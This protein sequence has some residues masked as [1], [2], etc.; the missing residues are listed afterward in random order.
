MSFPVTF[1]EF[2]KKTNSTKQPNAGTTPKKLFTDVTLKDDTD[3]LNPTLIIKWGEDLTFTPNYV[4]IAIFNRFYYVVNM[5]WIKGLWH[6]QCKVDVLATYK[7]KIGEQSLYVTRSSA[8]SDGNIIDTTYPAEGVPTIT[9]QL[10]T[11]PW[12]LSQDN[13]YCYV[14]GIA[15][16]STTFFAMTLSQLQIF[17]QDFVLSNSYCDA[18]YGSTAWLT[19]YPELKSLMNPLQYIVSIKWYPFEIS[20][21][22]VDNLKYGWIRVNGF[23]QLRKITNFLNAESQST[24]INNKHPQAVARGSY[25][26]NTHSTYRLLY[27]GFGQ[28]DLDSAI[29]SKSASLFTSVIV[30]VRT[31]EGT[32]YIEDD[33]LYELNQI[34][35]MIGVEYQIGQITKPGYGFGQYMQTSMSAFADVLSFNFGGAV[36]KVAGGVGDYAKS[37]VPS[38]RTIGTNGGINNLFGVISIQ[39]EFKLL[40]SE[41][42]TRK[43]RPLCLIKT[44]N[45]LTGFIQVDKADIDIA[46]A[47]GEQQEIRS[48]ME[49]G[50]YFE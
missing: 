49:G 43:G 13:G 26:N 7:T 2:P 4:E 17:L 18:I 40:V 19:T 45:T 12:S 50:F 6:I 27:P 22:S 16:E 21:A 9:N 32:L 15:G 25:L 31:G 14:V 23:T 44:I 35:S 38:I 48:Y 33:S 24:T 42:N 47:E 39:S 5:V 37:Q 34:T 28:I 29:V 41:D 36:N 20:G 10:S 1:Y 3:I 11:S 8:Q 46:T 30:D